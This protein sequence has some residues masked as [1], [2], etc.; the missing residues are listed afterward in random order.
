MHKVLLVS[1]IWQAKL[2]P[3]V[4][5]EY[6]LMGTNAGSLGASEPESCF[7]ALGWAARS[8]QVGVSVPVY[9]PVAKWFL[10]SANGVRPS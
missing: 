4:R 7:Q 2:K 10:K 6:T 3:Q 9:L 8:L 5:K 1:R